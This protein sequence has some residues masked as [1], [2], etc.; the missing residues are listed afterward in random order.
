MRLSS[1]AYVFVLVGCGDLVDGSLSIELRIENVVPSHVPSGGGVEITLFGNNFAD[2]AGVWVGDVEALGVVR[3]D[4]HR[5]TFVAPAAS[6]GPKSIVVTN[7]DGVT[8]ATTVDY[9]VETV[10][11]ALATTLDPGF[12]SIWGVATE[13]FDGDG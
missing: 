10:D 1:F 12:G 2:G 7:P 9:V 6:V 3:Q 11:F 13:D 5:M 8:A 4:A